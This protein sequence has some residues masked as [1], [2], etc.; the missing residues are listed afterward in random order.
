MRFKNYRFFLS[1][2]LLTAV[3]LLLNAQSI[4]NGKATLEWKDGVMELRSGDGKAGKVVFRPRFTNGTDIKSVKAFRIT[5]GKLAI[6][7]H[8]KDCSL[9]FTLDKRGAISR[10]SAPKNAVFSVETPTAAI[11]LP[12]GQ[13]DDLILEPGGKAR[14]LPP[15]LP[16]FMGLEGQGFWTLSCIPYLGRSDIRIS[17]DLKKWEFRPQPLEEYTFVIQSGKDIW[18]KVEEKLD[19][20]ERKTVAWK[21]PFPA[22]YRAAFPMSSDLYP[23]G[24]SKYQVWDI[25]EQKPNNK[26]PFHL[27]NRVYIMDKKAVTG[28]SSGIYG[29]L[30]YPAYIT[31]KGEVQMIYPKLRYT[32]CVFDSS[33]PVYIYTYDNGSYAKRPDTPV[34]FLEEYTRPVMTSRPSSSI[35]IGPATCALTKEIEQIY[36]RSEARE[37]RDL[38]CDKLARMQIF[39]ESIR[40]RIDQFRKWAVDRKKECL[41]AAGKDSA[42]APELKK[43]AAYFDCMEKVHQSKQA[44]MATPEKVW[45]LDEELLKKLDNKELDD[46]ALENH[47]KEYGRAIRTIG[48]AQDN[49]VAECHYVT[50]MLR[51]QALSGYMQSG[52]PTVREFYRKLYLSTNDMLQNSFN[53]EGK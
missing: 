24:E 6:L 27:A 7:L 14:D 40:T 46:E 36:Y 50:R 45:E 26:R 1:A 18:K 5:E 13:T 25:M 30:P 29:I 33:R 10:V 2:A 22:R 52:D 32:Q 51:L 21:P 3:P 53:H 28:W 38:I 42:A 48:G 15:F 12:D 11:V 19:T 41:A 49:C 44:R 9:T 23:V 43:F 31:I 37:K 16:F 47:C 34:N 4:S 35:G 20:K 17:A 8:G 39:V